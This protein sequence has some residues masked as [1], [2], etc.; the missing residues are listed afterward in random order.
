MYPFNILQ[1]C[2][3]HNDMCMKKLNAEKTIL[4]NL[5][6]YEFSKFKTNS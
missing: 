1:V 5:Q 4:T 6:H 3:G 2:Y